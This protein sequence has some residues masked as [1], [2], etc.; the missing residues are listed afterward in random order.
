MTE[1]YDK[2]AYTVAGA[3]SLSSTNVEKLLTGLDADRVLS[4][5][6]PLWA[7]VVF[8]GTNLPYWII[9]CTAGYDWIRLTLLNE[10]PADVHVCGHPA[11][12]FIAGL[13]VATSS[14]VMHGS[15]MRLG[16]C[17][18]CAHP[19]RS[20]Q[21]HELEWQKVFKRVDISCACLALFACVFCHAWSD[22]ALTLIVALPL[23]IGGIFLKRLKYH[24]LYLLAHG[25]W[26][27][28]TAMLVWDA[29]LKGR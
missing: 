1:L 11:L 6:I 20:E 27:V 5:V 21:F 3:S 25:A 8:L 4:E 17:F 18:C 12:Y 15:Q 22:L 19:V 7:K 14:T 10:S 23:F 28:V 26:H 16:S 24:Y 29:V 2:F 9:T 13:M